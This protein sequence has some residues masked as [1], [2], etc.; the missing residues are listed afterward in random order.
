MSPRLRSPKSIRSALL[1]SMVVPTLAV[2]AG[3]GSAAAQQGPEGYYVPG[4]QY[5]YPIAPGLYDYAPGSYG[6]APA[7]YDYAP[8]IYGY[9]PCFGVNCGLPG[10]HPRS[11]R[12]KPANGDHGNDGGNG[13]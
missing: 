4:L 6:Y 9:A 12:F 3:V 13:G 10:G 1:T 11:D 7:I 8:G 5:R 2:F